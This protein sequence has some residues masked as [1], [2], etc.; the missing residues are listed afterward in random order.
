LF[1]FG[2]WD[3]FYYVALKLLIGWPASL[4]T[5]DLLFLIPVSWL[6]PVL[7][8]VLNSVTMILMAL[9]L[10]GRQERG[11]YIK[12]SIS[13]WILIFGGALV[14]LYTY[15]IDYTKLLIESGV[16]A[17]SSPEAEERLMNMITNYIPESYR[18][19]LFIAG[20]VLILA[21]IAH[22]LLRSRKYAKD[23]K[24]D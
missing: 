19:P 9:L 16:T 13:D 7:A 18:W 6:G 5:W 24:V 14:I 12:V 8:P 20:E 11:Y 1:A 21:A 15:L 2:V 3:I 10:I 23:E 4:L 22:I 17:K